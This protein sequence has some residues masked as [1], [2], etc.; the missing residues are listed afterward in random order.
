MKLRLVTLAAFLQ[1]NLQVQYT[2]LL[3]TRLYNVQVCLSNL[4][5]VCSAVK[6]EGIYIY[7]YIYIERERERERIIHGCLEIPDLFRVL[8]ISH[9]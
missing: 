3:F 4:A 9:E 1:Q 5:S 6:S 2:T 7:I 8:N